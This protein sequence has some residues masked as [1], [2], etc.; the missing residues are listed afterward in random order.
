MCPF[1]SSTRTVGWNTRCVFIN[2]PRI[3][4]RSRYAVGESREER[5]VVLPRVCRC[6]SAN[7]GGSSVW[8]KIDGE[9]HDTDGQLDD[10]RCAMLMPRRNDEEPETRRKTRYW[11][12]IATVMKEVGQVFYKLTKISKM[13]LLIRVA[14]WQPKSHGLNSGCP[15]TTQMFRDKFGL[16]HNNPNT[17]GLIRVAP[18]QPK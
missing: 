11:A 13:Q 7:N 12:Q 3:L 15:T 6:R 18:Q 5:P 2:W 10:R 8:S 1:H 4:I 17:H 14:L 9:R 16:P